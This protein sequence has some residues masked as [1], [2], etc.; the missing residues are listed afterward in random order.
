MHEEVQVKGKVETLSEAQDLS[1]VAGAPG[2][3]CVCAALC[4]YQSKESANVAAIGI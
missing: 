3:A 2:C 4:T 1:A